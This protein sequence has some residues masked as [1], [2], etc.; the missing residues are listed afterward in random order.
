MTRRARRLG[1]PG[2]V[3]TP[4]RSPS[5]SVRRPKV[6]RRV[7]ARKL[8]RLAVGLPT[9]KGSSW[10]RPTLAQRRKARRTLRLRALTRAWAVRKLPGKVARWHWDRT[11]AKIPQPP[12]PAWRQTTIPLPKVT[13]A[14]GPKHLVP[15]TVTPTTEVRSMSSNPHQAITEAFAA[16][17][18]FQPESASDMER[19][20]S[21]QHEM[22][23]DIGASY[24]HLADRM[25]SEMPFGTEVANSTRD[26]GAAF[27]GLSGMAQVV[28]TTFRIVH[29]DDLARIEAP[30]PGEG[31]WD[32]SAQ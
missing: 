12:N 32:T 31:L 3:K 30:R 4:N 29:E 18:A 5:R 24:N 28:H 13:A 25:T 17:A 8:M 1:T 16:L 6:F 23:S 2:L 22:L 7:G 21:F 20:L 15:S 27:S 19:F 26:L 11:Q 9:R 14:P 10:K